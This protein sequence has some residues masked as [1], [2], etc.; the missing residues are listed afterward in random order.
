MISID[1]DEFVD[2]IEYQPAEIELEKSK[3]IKFKISKKQNNKNNKNK[4]FNDINNELNIKVKEV[5]KFKIKDNEYLEYKEKLFGKIK[6]DRIDNYCEFYLLSNDNLEQIKYFSNNIKEYALNSKCDDEHI[7]RM[8]KQIKKSKELYFVNP[9]AC[10]EYIDY[11]TE[12]PKDLIEI[13]DGHHRVN[14]LR[15]LCKELQYVETDIVFSFWVQIYKS[16][17]PDDKKSIEIFKKYN[18]VKPFSIDFNLTDLIIVICNKLNIEF[19]KNKFEFIKN[20]NQRTNKPSISKKEFTEKIEQRI[21]EQIKTIEYNDYS[22]IKIDNIITKFINY[23]NA[24][25]NEIEGLECFKKKYKTIKITEKIF[26][27]AIDNKCILG[28]LCI[29][30]VIKECVCL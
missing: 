2:A 26:K 11:L 13:I 15:K 21:K 12:T 8:I 30:D 28:L 25:L 10:I 29:D 6:P 3:P 24:L 23:N 5:K 7:A 9:I 22:D 17:I 19:N 1:N 18:N 27:K 16:S 14:C 20:T 4:V